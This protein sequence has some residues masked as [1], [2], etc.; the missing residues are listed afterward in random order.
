MPRPRPWPA[1]H[2]HSQEFDG[3]ARKNP[4][5]GGFGCVLLENGTGRHLEY[6]AG[7]L[8]GVTNNVAEWTALAAGMQVGWEV[9]LVVF[10][11]VGRGCWR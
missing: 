11:D 10:G 8:P 1:P 7:P 3:G 2:R 6:V 9:A 5:P 4:G